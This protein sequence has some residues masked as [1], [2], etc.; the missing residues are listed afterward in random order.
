MCFNI[1]G[2]GGASRRAE[3]LAQ[4]QATEKRTEETNKANSLRSGMEGINKA[5]GG[6][7]DAYFDRLKTD[8]M[9]YAQ[10]QLEDQYKDAKKNI[11]YALARK[12]S[13]NSSVMGDQQA[14]LDRQNA[15]NL[16]G[17][18]GTANDIANTARG[19]IASNKNQVVSQLDAT[20][21]DSAAVSDA[22]ERS[23][24]LAV[25]PSFNP[26]GK[27]FGDIAAQAAQ[28][29][30]AASSNPANSPYYAGGGYGNYGARLFGSSGSGYSVG[31]TS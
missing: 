3:Q 25:T 21:D 22:M 20:Y 30:T 11:V 13:L 18:T 26:L 7:D 27:M 28:A 5:F 10:P 16:T 19:Q 14:I 9:D 24:M 4:Q 15:T 6:F 2:D 8:Y 12:G 23:R 17:I 31:A 1:F 29:K